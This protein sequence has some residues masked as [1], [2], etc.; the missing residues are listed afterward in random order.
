VSLDTT[1]DYYDLFAK[2]VARIA[3]LNRRRDEIDVEIT[4]LR[5]L[6]RA[7]FPLIPADK[8][9]L[10]EKEIEEVEK[11]DFGLIYAIKLVFSKNKGVWMTPPEIR[12]HL[13]AMGF[14]L[15]KYRANP[16]AS[17]GTTV[18]RMGT[19]RIESK[20]LDNGQIAYRRRITLLEQLA[21]ERMPDR[22]DATK[23]TM[24]G[25]TKIKAMRDTFRGK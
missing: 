21:A 23:G 17:I 5:E 15:T 9:K 18:K 11:E 13:D 2:Y 7:T 14:D 8:Q 24:P 25:T 20:P 3:D 10:Y 1:I 19:E 4:K 6:M 22:S 12:D 16:L